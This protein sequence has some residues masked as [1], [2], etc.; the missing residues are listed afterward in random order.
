MTQASLDPQAARRGHTN[1]GA[2]P[3]PKLCKSPAGGTFWMGG[4]FKQLPCTAFKMLWLPS[5]GS[6][7]PLSKV[8]VCIGINFPP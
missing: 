7:A 8:M 5:T 1:L 6:L 4:A 3:S 2:V